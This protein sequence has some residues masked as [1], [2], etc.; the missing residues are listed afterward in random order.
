VQQQ[1]DAGI[2]DASSSCEPNRSSSRLPKAFR[3]E[4]ERSWSLEHAAFVAAHNATIE[5]EGLPLDAW[6][7]F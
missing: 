7:A 4:I 6:R 5:T 3:R 1:D 2:P